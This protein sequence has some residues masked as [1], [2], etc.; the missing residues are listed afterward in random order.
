VYLILLCFKVFGEQASQ[1]LQSVQPVQSFF[2]VHLA[3]DLSHSLSLLFSCSE[4][5]YEPSKFNGR[6]A[7][8]PFDDHNPPP[9]E[10]I[11]PF[12]QDVHQHLAEDENSV[13]CVH[14]KAG[15][16]RTGVMICCYM[17]HSRQFEESWRAL[18][19]YGEART[20]NA[21]VWRTLSS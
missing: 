6:S 3:I 5:W 9:F 11:E 15:K 12:C 2:L 21:K 14:C 10:M 20:Q 1:A 19:Y 7:Y 4:R 8:Y 17:L 16:G 18:Q 13:A